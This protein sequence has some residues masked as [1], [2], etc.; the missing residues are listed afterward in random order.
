M[1]Y[2]IG[3]A[4]AALALG[5]ASQAGA[6][7]LNLLNGDFE[8]GWSAGVDGRYTPS[9]ERL[10]PGWTDSS[11][12]GTGH[13]NPTSAHFVNEAA[14]GSAGFA[15]G[16]I[17]A[18]SSSSVLAQTLKD[19]VIQPNTR[20][21]LTVDIGRYFA[22]SAF[23]YDVGLI[24]GFNTDGTILA[25]QTGGTVFV[26]DGA[27]QSL[28]LSFE[29]AADGPEIG[30]TLTVALGG[31]GQFGGGATYDNVHL[32]AESLVAGAVPEPATW[33]MMIMGFGAAGAMV[34]RRRAAVAV[35]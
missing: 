2:I 22:Q 14:I 8:E 29:T 9:H 4:A 23:G 15:L 10:I 16:A 17:G 7:T 33:A 5:A 21:T 19:Y 20:Y 1:R 25:R 35:A 18:Q 3:A 27:F 30:R 6:A 26:T 31:N 12:S 28:S 24:S 13:W 32:T 34:R 11:G